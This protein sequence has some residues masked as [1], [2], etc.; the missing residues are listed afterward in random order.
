[1]E[2]LF[3][4]IGA[5]RHA[6]D[7][8]NRLEFIM[9]SNCY[10]QVRCKSADRRIMEVACQIPAFLTVVPIDERTIEIVFDIQN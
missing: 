10:L 2:K 7:Y 6:D 8:K 4:I 5:L 1:M 3:E 9:R